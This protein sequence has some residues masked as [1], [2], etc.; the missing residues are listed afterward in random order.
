MAFCQNCGAKLE[1][2]ESFCPACGAPTAAQQPHAAQQTPPASDFAATAQKLNDTPDTTA[3]FDQNDIAQNKAMAI[4]AYLGI[5]V[6]IPLFAAKNSKFARYHANQ[7]LVLFL[8]ELACSV[9]SGILS[10]LIPL[11]V[12]RL[13]FSLV[14]IALLV[15]VI[16]GI[17]N[18]AN[19][20][21]KEL[22]IIGKL[23]ILN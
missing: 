20:K 12:I 17:V 19:G 21:A 18:A 16:L 13:I 10:R 11:L 22:P 15:W 14:N 6:L 23:R 8:T 5:L 3:E 9:I 4:L 7:G 2:N 1:G